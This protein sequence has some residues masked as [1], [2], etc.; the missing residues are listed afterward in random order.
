MSFAILNGM[1]KKNIQETKNAEKKMKWNHL[2]DKGIWDPPVK[3][4]HMK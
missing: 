3:E 2:T 4:I 1:K